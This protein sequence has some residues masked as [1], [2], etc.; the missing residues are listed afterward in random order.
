M[1]NVIRFSFIGDP[2]IPNKGLITEGKTPWDTESLRLSIGVKV[3]DSTVFAGLY[4]S[5]KET[6]KTIDTDNQPMEINWEDRTDEQVREKVAGFRKY[7]TNIGSDETLTF[8]TGYDFISYLAAA[9]QD[10][11]DPIVVNGTCDLRYDNKGILRRNFNITGIWKARETDQKKLSLVGD[12]YFSSKALDKSCVDETKKM[13]LDSYV[14]QYINKDEGS[15][16][17]PFQT[18][19]SVAKYK[20]D[21]ER[22]Q[23]KKAFKLSCLEYK[24]NTIH[25]MMW[26]MRVVDGT[27]EVEFTEDQLTP[28]QKMQI[29][30]GTRTLEDFR[31]NGSIRGPRNHE[32][33]LFEPVCKGDFANGLVDSGMK[34]SEFEEKIYIPAK[35]E[36]IDSME[37][38]DNHSSSSPDD[39]DASDDELF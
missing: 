13:I 21:N 39:G 19:F 3:D 10:Y 6:I 24:K 12:L 37:S 38:A 33:R 29:E 9:L 23:K 26:E 36:S 35:D 8:I 15:M 20:D 4:D 30:L 14:L 18:V 2:V 17:V 27:E 11:N 25:H 1:S 31:P 7:R 16:F 5:V 28:M 34:L 22:H 32:I